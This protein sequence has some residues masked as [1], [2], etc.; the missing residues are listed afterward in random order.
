ME[1]RKN[2]GLARNTSAHSKALDAR[3]NKKT[4]TRCVA[5]DD[6]SLTSARF[7][8]RNRRIVW[9]PPGNSNFGATLNTPQQRSTGFGRSKFL[10]ARHCDTTANTIRDRNANDARAELRVAPREAR[11][12]RGKPVLQDDKLGP[13]RSGTNNATSLHSATP[14]SSCELAHAF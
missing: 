2:C 3:G 10:P 4:V 12:L 1:R 11:T 5:H 14:N 13:G 9:L 7:A 8:E 6:G